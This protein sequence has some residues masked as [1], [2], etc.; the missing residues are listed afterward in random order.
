MALTWILIWMIWFSLH[1]ISSLLCSSQYRYHHCRSDSS[2]F[3]FID[4]TH[5][6]NQKLICW[7]LI[8]FS[9]CKCRISYFRWLLLD[10]WNECNVFLV[11]EIWNT[12]LKVE[13]MSLQSQ[14]MVHRKKH[15]Q[16]EWR[17]RREWQWIFCHNLKCNKDMDNMNYYRLWRLTE[18]I[19]YSLCLPVSCSF[20]LKRQCVRVV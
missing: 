2:S 19:T 12:P 3:S 13:L 10:L 20:A 17:M 8:H 18:F 11:F 7:M 4:N 9:Y 14:K 16:T 1:L 15:K 6:K 5:T